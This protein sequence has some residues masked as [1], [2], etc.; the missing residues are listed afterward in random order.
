MSNI[1]FKNH[2][3]LFPE[4]TAAS[5]AS[6]MACWVYSF[7]K[8]LIMYSFIAEKGRASQGREGGQ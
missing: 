6:L 1:V 2:R 4:F 5:T 8:D 7:I 3:N